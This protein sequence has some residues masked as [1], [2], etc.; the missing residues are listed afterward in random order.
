MSAYEMHVAKLFRGAPQ[1]RSEWSGVLDLV[2]PGLD[3]LAPQELFQQSL[4]LVSNAA[5]TRRYASVRDTAQATLRSARVDILV[6]EQRRKIRL[7]PS[8]DLKRTQRRWLGQ[9]GLQLYFTQL[10]Q[11]DTAVIDLWPS[12][13][14]INAAGDA[15]WNPR[16]LYVRWDAEFIGAVRDVY[17]GFFIDD[18]AQFQAGL[19]KLGVEAAGGLALRHLGEGTQR[20]VRFST[21]HLGAT[22]REISDLNLNLS[23]AGTLS[24]NFV[25]FGLYLLSLHELLESLDCSFDVRSAFMRSYRRF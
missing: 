22:L 8:S 1:P 24:R 19:R 17:A 16:P 23:R 6:E 13:L 18:Q 9:L 4:E 11:G 10:F 14:G 7:V 20:G 12:R 5:N 21:A 3:L 2:T 15:I 25:A